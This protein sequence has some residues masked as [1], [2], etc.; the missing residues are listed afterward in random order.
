MPYLLI[1]LFHTIYF[2][3]RAAQD[4]DYALARIEK[5]GGKVLRYGRVGIYLKS[6]FVG[7]RL[8]PLHFWY[9]VNYPT[10]CGTWFVVTSSNTTP[11]G[12]WFWRD[13][14]GKDGLPAMG[15]SGLCTPKV[16]FL[17]MLT[18]YALTIAVVTAL[19]VLMFKVLS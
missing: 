6:P 9:Q 15:S 17:E 16:R 2:R 7:V 12:E 5:E 13:A 1:A 8:Y 19:V 14:E 10:R 18:G 4:R 11:M 3:G